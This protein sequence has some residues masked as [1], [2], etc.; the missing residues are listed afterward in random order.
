MATNLEK[1]MDIHQRIPGDLVSE[2]V[3]Q[4]IQEAQ[5]LITYVA[6][7]GVIKMDEKALKVI[8]RS[9]YLLEEDLWTVEAEIAFWTMLDKLTAQINPVSIQSLKSI[10]PTCD[11]SNPS[12][13]KNKQT[14]A[15][16]AVRF[17]RVLAMLCMVIL[18]F[19]QVYWVIGS[20]LKENLRSIFEQREKTVLELEQI[21]VIQNNAKD[22]ENNPQK[23]KVESKLEVLNQTLDANYELLLGWSRVWQCL[24]GKNQFE[25]KV[26]QYVQY[27]HDMKMKE[28]ERESEVKDL[29]E[30][31]KLKHALDIARNK[32]FLTELSAGFI[33]RALQIYLLPLLYGLLGATTF[34]LRTLSLEIRNLTFTRDSAIRYGLRLSL[35]ALAGM[36]IGWFLKPDDVSFVSSLSPLAIAF[37]MGYN[38]DVLF[39]IMDRIIENLT[40][41]LKTLKTSS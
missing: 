35:G 27:K 29:I 38:V 3:K 33:L 39:T 20:D 6:N 40:G 31:E 17:Y 21:R 11:H 19:A 30:A 9:K 25:G 22:S 13:K 26:T 8:V 15:T 7:Q 2:E 24:L 32:M 23:L 14:V 34:V 4:T 10:V 36:A 28:L 18:L 5:H 37:L 41:K 1:S 16:H 12:R